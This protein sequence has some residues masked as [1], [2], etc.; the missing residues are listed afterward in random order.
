MLAHPGDTST[1]TSLL[2]RGQESLSVLRT[3][4]VRRPQALVSF[5]ERDPSLILNLFGKINMPCVVCLFVCFYPRLGFTSIMQVFF[6][7]SLYDF[8]SLFLLPHLEEDK[9]TEKGTVK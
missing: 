8:L 6:K 3:C 4:A 5:T 9:E 1:P 2:A 7:V